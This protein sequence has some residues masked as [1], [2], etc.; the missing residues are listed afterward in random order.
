MHPPMLEFGE[1]MHYMPV[2]VHQHGKLAART[3]D[4]VYL[5]VN[6]ST[7][8]SYVGTGTGIYTSRSLHRKPIDERWVANEILGVRGTP[9]R[10]CLRTDDNNIRARLPDDQETEQQ[11]RE[12]LLGDDGQTTR[13]FKI[14]NRDIITY[15]ATPHCTGCHSQSHNMKAKPHTIAYRERFQQ[16]MEQDE[17]DCRRIAHCRQRSDAY[18]E[19][20]IREHDENDN[21][22]ET[23]SL[24]SNIANL[25]EEPPP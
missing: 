11:R 23:E 24:P 12:R 18:L 8:E 7:E 14:A 3:Q 6:M 9:W 15:G 16:L 4:G 10:P 21:N 5:G 19:R 17:I 22:N 13:Q 25:P 1:C 2:D 20:K